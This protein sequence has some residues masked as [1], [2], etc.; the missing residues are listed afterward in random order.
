[1]TRQLISHMPANL[2]TYPTWTLFHSRSSSKLLSSVALSCAVMASVSVAISSASV[3]LI[4]KTP[5][6]F[7]SFSFSVSFSS[8]SFSRSPSPTPEALKVPLPTV[9]AVHV[10]L[11]LGVTLSFPSPETIPS[12]S[13]S[14]F[15][16]P[17]AFMVILSG[18]ASLALA[19]RVSAFPPVAALVKPCRAL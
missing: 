7:F 11:M 10:K 12:P 15:R 6:F 5:S 18:L 1:M 8:S 4:P 19:E 13:R 2:R 17:E 14:V 3:E 9:G 16:T